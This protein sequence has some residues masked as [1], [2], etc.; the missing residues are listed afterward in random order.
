METWIWILLIIIAFTIAIIA[1]GFGIYGT[2][3]PFTTN[4]EQ[5]N[6]DITVPEDSSGSVVYDKV[7]NACVAIYAR[8][9]SGYQAG[10][11]FIYN[12]QDDGTLLIVT[13]AHVVEGVSAINIVISNANGQSN[14]NIQIPCS[15][16]DMDLA[17]DIAL[18]QSTDSGYDFQS[19]LE[20]ADND[21]LKIGSMI[22][23]VGNPLANDYLS[24]ASGTLRDNKYVNTSNGGSVES[25]YASVPIAPGNSGG[26]YLNAEGLVIGL[27]NW[28]VTR[29]GQDLN[30]FSGGLNCYMASRI[31]PRLLSSTNNKGYLGLAD[32]TVLSG[33]I[34]MNLRT[35]YPAFNN[36]GYD[37]VQGIYVVELD[38]ENI[39]ISNSRCS[40]AGIEVGDII[41]SI[42]DTN[43]GVF[44][45]E[46]SPTR[47]S[48]FIT[49]GDTV[50]MNVVRPSTVQLL[51]FNVILDTFPVDRDYV[52]T[53]YC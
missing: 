25:I 32:L 3:R 4:V 36:S 16:I 26:P 19:Y 39:D 49:P 7:K 17:A 21:T 27:A 23:T 8:E 41:L 42:N 9:S 34:L 14:N 6:Y 33:P 37:K 46:Y 45:N 22:Y 43:L 15:I 47:V 20:W 12:V 28:V 11:G 50:T 18:L 29:N 44:D 48:W 53:T 1:L 10:S 31:V 52:F 24:I 30:N 35:V 13:A 51:T 2:V 38:T 5:N 40:N